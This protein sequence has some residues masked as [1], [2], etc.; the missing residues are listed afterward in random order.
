MISRRN[1]VSVNDETFWSFIAGRKSLQ[2]G[3]IGRHG[4]PHMASLWF[5]IDQHAVILIS[6][7]RTQ[8]VE[9]LRRDSHV[10]L[11]WEDGS[12]KEKLAGAS[13]Y[14]HAELI[15]GA[16]AD[17]AYETLAHHHLQILRHY[18]DHGLSDEQVDKLLR[19]TCAKKTAIIIR[20]EKVV[21]WDHS[22]LCG[23]Y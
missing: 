13:V 11:L 3:T 2:I 21:T 16:D 7:S 10:T 17:R 22:N 1:P 19:D 8:K 12:N 9:N 6:Y 20:P 5:A 14:G 23:V 18:G 4:W 15:H